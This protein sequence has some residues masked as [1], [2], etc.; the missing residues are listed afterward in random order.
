[1]KKI[2]KERGK[3]KGR[4]GRGHNIVMTGTRLLLNMHPPYFLSRKRLRLSTVRW[5]LDASVQW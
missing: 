4:N 1:M 2:V 3:E 5:K